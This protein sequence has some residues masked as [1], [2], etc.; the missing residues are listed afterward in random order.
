MVNA[1]EVACSIMAGVAPIGQ[2]EL[3]VVGHLPD[4]QLED[5]E[6]IVLGRCPEP[7]VAAH[8]SRP[9]ERG[10]EAVDGH[11]CRADEVDLVIPRPCGRQ[12]QSRAADPARDD[13]ARVEHRVQLARERAPHPRRVVD[14]VHDDE[15][16]VEGEPT[17]HSTHRAGEHEVVELAEPCVHAA[18]HTVG[19][20][21]A[22]LEQAVAPR[23]RLD[24]QVAGGVAGAPRAVEEEVLDVGAVRQRDEPLGPRAERLPSHADG[25]DLVDEHDA[26]SAPLA[27]ELLGPACEEPDDDRVD[28]DEGGGEARARHRDERRVEARR[29]RLGEHGL[30]RTRRAE[31]QQSPLALAAGALELLSRLPDVDDAPHLFL[32]LDLSADVLELD[33]PFR[34]A[35]L[36]RLHLRHVHE[37]KRAEHDREVGEEQE[38]DEDG[39]DPERG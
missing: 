19:N 14:S 33:S 10:I 25:I 37:E 27:G 8:A 23:P 32:R 9:D 7:D 28:P 15:E 4:V 39:L 1:I 35:R 13:E 26:L 31:E 2:V 5:V 34:V 16:L 12:A 6:P 22:L 24:D 36:E 29:D 20:R 18:R 21:G 11:V 30:A 17:A 3:R 38:E